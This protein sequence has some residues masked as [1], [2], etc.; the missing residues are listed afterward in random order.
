MVSQ[1]QLKDEQIAL[2][3]N[4]VT[5][6]FHLP[7]PTLWE[8]LRGQKTELPLDADLNNLPLNKN[9]KKPVIAVNRA[10]FEVPRGE[11]FGVLGPNGSGKSTLIRLICTLL[12]PDMGDV[13]VFGFDVQRDEMAVKNL[14][15]RVSVDAAFFKKLSP[16]ENLLYGARLYGL[17]GKDAQRKASEI[18]ERL[19]LEKS[20][21]YEPME[22]MS[23]GMQ[24]KVAIAR[25]FITTPVLLL[26]DEPTTGL[27]PRSKLEVRAF[28]EE[29][30]DTHDATIIITTHDMDEADA[31]CDRISVIH[32]GKT[33]ALDTPEGLKRTIPQNGHVPTLE[34]VF[35]HLTGEQLVDHDGIEAPEMV[36]A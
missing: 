32:K 36:T 6:G 30:R 11:I 4:N 19:G 18:M 35:M 15:S 9:G 10:H 3:V 31:L 24:Q 14:I 8:R 27:D 2:S 13:S 26:L 23:R 5:K 34:D 29:L 20:T 17:S 21:Y 33:V 7:Q 25:A 28:V 12:T 22:E 1:L 16:M